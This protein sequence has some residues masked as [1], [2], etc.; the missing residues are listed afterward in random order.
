MQINL[1][2][3]TH[4]LNLDD[5]EHKIIIIHILCFNDNNNEL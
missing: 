5:E 4:L 1:L 3:G 2:N